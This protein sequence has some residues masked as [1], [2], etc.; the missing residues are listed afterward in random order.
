M[1]LGLMIAKTMLIGGHV[2]LRLRQI[3]A[4][5]NQECHSPTKSC[6]AGV[7]DAEGGDACVA[8]GGGGRRSGEEDEGDASVPTPIHASPAPTA[9]I[10]PSPFHVTRDPRRSTP[11][12]LPASDLSG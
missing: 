2:D 4:R 1:E 5:F 7:V 11:P 6:K 12:G 9:T 3:S 8:L 10:Y